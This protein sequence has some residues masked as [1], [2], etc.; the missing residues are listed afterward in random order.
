M[1]RILQ[2]VGR[3]A[4][5]LLDRQ[6]QGLGWSIQELIGGDK[7]ALDSVLNLRERLQ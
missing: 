6:G 5:V 7:D 2:A 1:G 3:L 4:F